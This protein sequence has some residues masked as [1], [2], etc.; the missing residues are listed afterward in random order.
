MSSYKVVDTQFELRRDVVSLA[1]I[2]HAPIK[3]PTGEAKTFILSANISRHKSEKW[4]W[5]NGSVSVLDSDGESWGGIVSVN[6]D[7]VIRL[8]PSPKDSNADHQP[9]SRPKTP[10][11]DPVSRRWNSPPFQHPSA[12]C[13][14]HRKNPRI[15]QRDAADE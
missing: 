3:Q 13:C 15:L 5:S 2:V 14:N 8:V 4:G 1:Q 11:A 9:A 7:D 12:K 6:T 10:A